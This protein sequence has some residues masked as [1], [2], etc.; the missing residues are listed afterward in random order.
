MGTKMVRKQFY[1]LKRQDELLKRLAEARGVSE[2]EIVRQ[3]IEREVA[4]TTSQRAA[5]E[6]SAWQEV[7]AFVEARQAA[8]IRGQPYRWNREE[9][10]AE[11]ENRRLWDK[12]QE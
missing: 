7:V 3:A 1:I 10:Y 6:R 2:A 8:G 4:G 12:N 11:R 9:I 5:I